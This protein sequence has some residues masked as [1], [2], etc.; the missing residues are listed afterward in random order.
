MRVILGIA[1]P[2]PR[3]A[4]PLR[5]AD[6][7][8]ISQWLRNR[9]RR[10]VG[11]RT[12]LAQ[13]TRGYDGTSGSRHRGRL[14][15]EAARCDIVIDERGIPAVPAQASPPRRQRR[16]DLSG[17]C[18]RVVAN[19]DDLDRNR[20]TAT[21]APKAATALLAI[22]PGVS[23]RQAGGRAR[24]MVAPGSAAAVAR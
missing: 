20:A 9:Q 19:G 21:V 11:K 16:P 4:S 8:A 13:P 18:C 17:E 5:M 23:T 6:R 10:D 24:H 14:R 7:A 12:P 3:N 22:P 1:A 2:R 15:L